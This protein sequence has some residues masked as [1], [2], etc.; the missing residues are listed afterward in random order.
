MKETASFHLEKELACEILFLKVGVFGAEM[1]HSTHFHD[2]WES[3]TVPKAHHF[4]GKELS[5][6]PCPPFHNLSQA[7]LVN[8]AK[9]SISLVVPKIYH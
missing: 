9:H 6:L 5:R 2:L 1:L 3:L 8:S 4:T 7:K